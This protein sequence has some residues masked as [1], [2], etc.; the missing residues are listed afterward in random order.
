MPL[1]GVETWDIRQRARAMVLVQK[2][3]GADV[4]VHLFPASAADHPPA[5]SFAEYVLRHGE[6]LETQE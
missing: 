2:R 4:E 1:K 3:V 5:G 6:R